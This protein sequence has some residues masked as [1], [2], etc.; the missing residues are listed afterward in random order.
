MSA[1]P[2]STLIPSVEITRTPV[3][4]AMS[5]FRPTATI[6]SPAMSTTPFSIAGPP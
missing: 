4:T 2:G 3:G 1:S 5:V 6:R